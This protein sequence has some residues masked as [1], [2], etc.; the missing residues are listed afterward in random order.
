MQ[1]AAL[2]AVAEAHPVEADRA[3]REVQLAR[4]GGVRHLPRHGDAA[5]AV[6]HQADILEDAGDAARDPAGHIG[7]LEGERQGGRDH[8]HLDPPLQ[9]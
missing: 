5:H 2:G 1:H 4:A 7:D 6:L 9:P 8:R 3:A